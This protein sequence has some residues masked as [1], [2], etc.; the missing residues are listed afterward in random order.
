MVTFKRESIEARQAAVAERRKRTSAGG[1]RVD[2]N[3]YVYG[4]PFTEGEQ[5]GVLLYAQE[6]V[7]SHARK[8][9]KVTIGIDGPNGGSRVYANILSHEEPDIDSK[10]S[11]KRLNRLMEFLNAIDK[12]TYEAL[13]ACKIGELDSKYWKS[14]SSKRFWCSISSWEKRSTDEGGNETVELAPS[15][16]YFIGNRD[17]PASVK[18]ESS[19]TASKEEEELPF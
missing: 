9:L 3:D 19:G 2:F 11:E 12:P 8:A 16:K 6:G 15:V 5:V 13:V 4:A 18:Q 14:L 10:E 17:L 7:D 1:G